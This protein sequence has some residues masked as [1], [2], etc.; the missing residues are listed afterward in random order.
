MVKAS[1]KHAGKGKRTVKKASK[2]KGKC[3]IIKDAKTGDRRR[4]SLSSLPRKKD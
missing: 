1:F 4:V 2:D 3:V